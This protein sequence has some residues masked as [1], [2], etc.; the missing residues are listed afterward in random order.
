MVRTGERRF[1]VYGC[2]ARLPKSKLEAHEF[3]CEHG[4]VRCKYA[5][6]GCDEVMAVLLREWRGASMY[7][8]PD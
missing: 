6:K 8:W 2:D 4:A 1:H 3:T 5:K 7:G